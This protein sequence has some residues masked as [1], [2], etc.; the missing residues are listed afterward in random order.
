[1]CN[2][3]E[4][5]NNTVHN[6]YPLSPVAYAACFL[7]FFSFSYSDKHLRLYTTGLLTKAAER[8]DG[9]F[10]LAQNVRK[11]IIRE[12]GCFLFDTL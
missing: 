3:C 11:E 4:Q 7:S 8:D 9:G 6:V 10:Y 2:N 1:M 12:C 5:C